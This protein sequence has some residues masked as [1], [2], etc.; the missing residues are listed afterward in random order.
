[1]LAL[2]THVHVC[3]RVSKMVDFSLREVAK[4]TIW[5]DTTGSLVQTQQM[6]RVEFPDLT[7]CDFSF[8]G[9]IFEVPR[10]PPEAQRFRRLEAEDYGLLRGY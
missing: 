4:L 3:F 2:A 10:V 6:S 7:P 9:Y 8:C 1:M 5:Y